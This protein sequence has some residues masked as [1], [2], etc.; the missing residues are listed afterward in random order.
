[1]RIVDAHLH[2]WD[3]QQVPIVWFRDDLGLPRRADVADVRRELEGE[4]AY[5]RIHRVERAVVV[6]AADTVDELRWLLDRA[7]RHRLVAAVVAQYEPKAGNWAGAAQQL[8]EHP[9]LAGIRLAV[10]TRAADLSDI[11][12]VDA[13]AAGLA[14]TGG[15][16]EVLIRSEQLPAVAALA[17][18][19]EDLSIV[20]CHLGLGTADPDDSWRTGLRTLAARPGVTAKVSG[21][22]KPGDDQAR[23]SRIVSDAVEILGADRLMFG[24][25][26]PISTRTCRYPETIARTIEALPAL[27]DDEADSFWW[28]L[29]T[30]LYLA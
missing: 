4:T 16:L 5:S 30:R 27:T 24:S 21:L 12:G 15:V 22:H 1:M 26:W 9:A 20:V 7:E 23:V 13:L 18:A 10:P 2:L 29:A 28:G 14:T 3:V 19:H 8:L 25:D 17:A 11:E 6:Q